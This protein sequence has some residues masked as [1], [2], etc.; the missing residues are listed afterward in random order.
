MIGSN[1]HLCYTANSYDMVYTAGS[2]VDTDVNKYLVQFVD[3]LGSEN[4]ARI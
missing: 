1:G 3:I 2:L 4:I